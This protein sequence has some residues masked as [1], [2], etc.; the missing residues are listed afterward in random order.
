RDQAQDRRVPVQVGLEPR[1]RHEYRAGVG[2]GTDTGARALLGWEHRRINRRGHRMDAEIRVS[3]IYQSLSSR[4]SIP[5]A[6]PRS[7]RLEFTAAVLDEQS[8]T[9]DSSLYKLGVGRSVARGRWREAL[10]LN[11]QREDFQVG[12]TDETT[13]LLIPGISYLLVRADNR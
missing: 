6:D 13:A 3:E 8:D 4:Y 11:Y 12:L 1:K 2:F 7:D 5:L 10:T 9:V